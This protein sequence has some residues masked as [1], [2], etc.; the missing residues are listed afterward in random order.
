M[1]E[2]ARAVP[3]LAGMPVQRAWIAPVPFTP[4]QQPLLG[5][6]PG[7]ANLYVCAGF[8][9]ALITAPMACEWLASQIV[10]DGNVG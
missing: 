2:A 10:G 1:S 6:V 5:L 7:Y 4:D 9:S 3:A 8:K